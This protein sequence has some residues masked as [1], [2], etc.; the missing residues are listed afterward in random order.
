MSALLLPFATRISDLNLVSP[1][2][3]PRGAA[4]NCQCPGCDRPVIARQGTEREWHFAH[5]KGGACQQGYEVSI[6]EIAKQMIRDRRELLLPALDIEVSATDSFG[7]R[8]EERMHVLNAKTV[9]LDECKT[10]QKR[11][12]VTAD[13]AGRLA[14]REILVEITVFHRLMPEKRDRLIATRIPSLQ[15]DLGEFKVS[16]ATRAKIEVALFENAMNRHWLHHPRMEQARR[17]AQTKLDAKLAQRRAEWQLVEE[18]RQE[19]HAKRQQE[20]AEIQFSLPSL[21]ERSAEPITFNRPLLGS[22]AMWRASFPTRENILR[23]SQS[24]AARTEL[25]ITN[26]MAVIGTITSRRQLATT[27][28]ANLATEWAAALNLPE[29]EILKFLHEAGYILV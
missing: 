14:D 16:Q 15:I 25:G 2:E 24:L 6:H 10:S 20:L 27:T 18:K 7:L 17:E 4:C 22:E 19:E 13:V 29:D 5:A 8:I 11:D 9:H 12:E 23:A 1:D 26:V 3:V 28:P 21:L